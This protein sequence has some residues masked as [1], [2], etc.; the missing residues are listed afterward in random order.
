MIDTI[1]VE[2]LEGS[3]LELSD[4]LISGLRHAAIKIMVGVEITI[5]SEASPRIVSNSV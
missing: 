1:V 3:Y 5:T 4:D 2:E